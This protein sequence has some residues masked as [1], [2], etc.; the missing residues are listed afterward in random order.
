MDLIYLYY[1]CFQRSFDDSQQIK[2]RMESLA[3]EEIFIMTESKQLNLV[4]SFMHEDENTLCPF[5]ERK[6]EVSRLSFLCRET[7]KP[8]K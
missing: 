1:N 7:I 4:W 2:I 3:C 8:N 5:G 6:M